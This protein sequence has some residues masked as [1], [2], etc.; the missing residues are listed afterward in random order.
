M[1]VIKHY[2]HS[3][4]IDYKPEVRKGLHTGTQN[5]AQL[6]LTQIG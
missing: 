5:T 2:F 4:R 3:Y 1:I 6:V